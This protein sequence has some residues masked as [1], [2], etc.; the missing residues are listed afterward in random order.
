MIRAGVSI[1]KLV[2]ETAA[3]RS[4]L[5][6]LSM[7]P[8]AALTL[9]HLPVE[10]PAFAAN[11]MP[12]IEAAR[13]QHPWLARCN[14]GY[15]VHEYQAI[16]D[17]TYMDDKFR[18]SMDSITEI[19]GARGT[20]W[21]Q[22]MDDLMLA[23]TGEEH[24]RIRNSVAASFTPRNIDRYRH[25]MREVV[26]RLLDEWAPKRAFDF[27]EFAACFPITVM[28]GLI[29][30]S[31]DAL[32]AIRKSLETQG[33]SASLDR[34][35]LPAMQA[36]FEALWSFVDKLIVERQRQ[37][38]GDQ[39]DVLNTLIAANRSSQ[40]NDAELRNAVFFAQ[41]AARAPRPMRPNASCCSS[42]RRETIRRS[43]AWP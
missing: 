20:S 4:E 38:G 7:Q 30:A 23:K 28:F 13:R 43:C 2:R 34:S 18:P 10:E 37:G 42:L 9:P 22:F 12:Y 6:G 11:P 27:A 25:L 14:V 8:V 21:G 15:V 17:L 16:H 36:A 24:A 3:G 5:R 31:P 32:P 26:P 40:I 39:D 33:L 41:L 35:L 19:M 29:D 1:N